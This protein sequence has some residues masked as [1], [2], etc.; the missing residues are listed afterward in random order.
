MSNAIRIDRLDKNFIINGGFDFFQRGGSFGNSAVNISTTPTYLAPD[1]YKVSF[2]GTVTGT[3]KVSQVASTLNGKAKWAIQYTAQRNASSLNL[4]MEQRIEGI[5]A[6]ELTAIGSAGF[7][8]QVFSP[9]SGTQLQLTLN[10]PTSEDNYT[11]VTQFFQ[12]TSSTTIAAS[13]WTQVNFTN[14]AVPSNAANGIS[15]IATLIV[16]SG[17]DGSAQNYQFTQLHLNSGITIPVF[18]RHGKNISAELTACQ[19]FYEKSYDTTVNPGSATG[20][21]AVF[22]TGRSTDG[23]AYFNFKFSTVKRAIGTT[24]I[25]EQS[26]AGQGTFT[27]SMSS[28]TFGTT[29]GISGSDAYQQATDAEL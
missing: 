28:F 4:V 7:S 21:G 12:S 10:Y 2:A 8:I 14:I 23:F 26:G 15:V 6:R 25:W 16:P 19:R 11:T 20:S 1:R 29:I 18:S 27:S 5:E 22:G 13:T 24:Q 17:T 3:P 9:I